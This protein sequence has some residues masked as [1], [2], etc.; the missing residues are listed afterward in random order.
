MKNNA[1]YFLAKFQQ[2]NIPLLA[3]SLAYYFL[4]AL[5]PLLITGLAIIP[6]FNIDPNSLVSVIRSLLPAEAASLIED[7][8]VSFVETPRGGLLTIGIIGTLW[9]A[10]GGVNAFIKASNEAYGVTESRSMIRVRLIALGLTVGIIF[11][12]LVAML[13]PVFG[14]L[15]VQF[16]TFLFPISASMSLLFHVI[17]WSISIVVLTAFLICLYRFAP[18][19]TIPFKHILPGAL[20]ASILWQ[21]ISLG[22]SF[23]VSNF[24]NY[25]ATY[26]SLGGIIILMI[27]FYLT[28]L[29]LLIG[30]LFTTIHHEKQTEKQTE[31][32]KAAGI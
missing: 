9:S 2:H 15:I 25:S 12:I 28:G 32:N 17:R 6:Y 3:A 7:N 23:Y 22:F 16:M 29:I 19:R 1:K 8:I 31:L 18:N 5:F 30:A 10:S 4:L 14:D 24:G 11:A 21:L 20:F 26:G 13:L 27:W